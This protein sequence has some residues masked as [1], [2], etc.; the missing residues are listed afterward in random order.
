[1]KQVTQKIVKLMEAIGA[2]PKNSVNKFH[3]YK[4]R[5]HEDVMNALQP[6]LV[7]AGLLLVPT[8]KKVTLV[9]PGH[10]LIEVRYKLT[11]GDESIEFVGI[12]EGQ[13]VSKDG[14][15]GDKASYKAQTGALKYALNDMLALGTQDDP[16]ADINTHADKPREIPKR[17][18]P[19]MQDWAAALESAGSLDELA[20]TW[21]KVPD[22]HKG[23]LTAMK[24]N[25]KRKLGGK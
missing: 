20:A 3:N 11:D 23:P 2:I 16:E 21:A 19:P 9:A 5:S 8:E 6:A 25:L 1:M 4:Y 13:D 7:K 24:D 22:K 18:E 17:D 14:K 15:A 12:G 10:V